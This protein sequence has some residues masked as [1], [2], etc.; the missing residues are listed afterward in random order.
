MSEVTHGESKALVISDISDV[1]KLDSLNRES[2]KIICYEK[3]VNAVVAT[4]VGLATLATIC[5][6][7]Y[8]LIKDHNK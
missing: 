5:A 2:Y 3:Q 1:T 8:Y 6:K 4:L 7:L